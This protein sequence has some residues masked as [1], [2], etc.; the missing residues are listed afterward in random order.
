MNKPDDQKDFVPGDEKL[1]AG[2]DY[3]GIQEL[4]ND[5]PTWWLI[6]FWGCIIWGG[7][8]M[9]YVH[10]LGNWV[11]ED[12]YKSEISIAEKAKQAQ[13]AQLGQLSDADRAKLLASQGKA[14]YAA[15]CAVCH[16]ADGGGT[17]GPNLTDDVSIY[18]FRPEEI[19]G[20]ITKGPPRGLPNAQGQQLS[21]DDIDALAAY[22][23]SLKGTKAPGGKA[24]EGPHPAEA[25]PAPAAA[26]AAGV[27]PKLAAALGKA[28]A[29]AACHQ[30]EVTGLGPS[31]KAIQARLGKD[32]ALIKAATAKVLNGTIGKPSQYGLP[33]TSMMPPNSAMVNAEEAD[34]IVRH[35]V[36]TGKLTP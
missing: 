11:I 15:K 27:D 26:A 23:L 21:P 31:L 30:P 33:A 36:A 7:L 6:M 12:E 17:V 18:G 29:C 2:H 13:K 25:V 24:A 14:L 9:I 4:D 34:L 10:C 19:K 1:I 16:R 22:V 20:V 3:D 35:L 5:L 8:Y 28:M 32:E